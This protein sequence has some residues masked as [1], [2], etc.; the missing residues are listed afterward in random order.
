MASGGGGS[1]YSFYYDFDISLFESSASELPSWVKKN[2]IDTNVK[3]TKVEKI[4]QFLFSR[5]SSN[6]MYE[7]LMSFLN[8]FGW[9]NIVN[10]IWS[11]DLPT[12]GDDSQ[13]LPAVIGGSDLGIDFL[14]LLIAGV[15]YIEDNLEELEKTSRLRRIEKL[16]TEIKE[17]LSDE[18]KLNKLLGKSLNL[19]ASKEVVKSVGDTFDFSK[20]WQVET[21]PSVEQKFY[22]TKEMV[23][24][25]RITFSNEHEG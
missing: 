1:S 2:L 6:F 17:V 21:Y 9:T 7:T 3:L 16:D 11:D 18:E 19:G 20:M 22:L 12:T 4:Q 8:T 10:K 24:L 5:I 15:D 23:N 14:T 13:Y 25:L